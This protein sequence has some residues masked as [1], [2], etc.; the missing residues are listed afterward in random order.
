[1]STHGVKAA[2]REKEVDGKPRPARFR[3]PALAG[4]RR[5]ALRAVVLASVSLPPAAAQAC[6][7]GCGVFDVGAGTLVTR[8]S[9]SDS[10]FSAW[11]RYAYMNQDQNW[12]KGSK[13]P[14]SDNL[15][16]RILTSFFIPGAEYS[17]SRSLT[18]MAEL[19]VFARALTTTDDGSVFGP[20][21][22]VYTGTLTDM[23]DL[24]LT[25][26]YTGFSEDMSTG[27]SFGVKLPTG[28]YTGPNGPLS[29]SEFDRDSLP[30]TGSTDVTVGAYHVGGLTPDN[31]LAYF[32]Q[33]RYEVAVFTRNAYRPGNELDAAV[34]LTYAISLGGS[35]A[36]S[37]VL[38]LIGSYRLRDQGANADSLNTGYARLLLSPGV[39]LK[40]AKTRLFLDVEF[41]VYQYVNAAPSVALEGSAGQLVAS[42]IFKAQVMYDF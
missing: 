20:A 9:D 34:G 33:A 42:V 23:G 32:A 11:L 41:P 12:E 6:A 16:K 4:A 7:C 14:A 38:Q 5:L 27:L 22:S 18:L 25:A 39:E 3:G 40:V 2:G 29:G 37:P 10:G 30:G 28:N 36:V 19:P 8:P 21:G 24:M 15:D 1:M 35:S 26:F 17:V 13:A 31:A